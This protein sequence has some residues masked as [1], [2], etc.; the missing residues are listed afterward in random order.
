M[1]I[2]KIPGDIAHNLIKINNCVGLS[3]VTPFCVHF[4]DLD[5]I[6]SK[7]ISKF[8]SQTG[9]GRWIDFVCQLLTL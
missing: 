2:G 8:S 5:L 7:I 1:T 4:V 6:L 3:D 9:R